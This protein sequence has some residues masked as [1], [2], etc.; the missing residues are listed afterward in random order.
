[1]VKIVVEQQTGYDTPT[2]AQK[3]KD[4]V[5]V[6][7]K[8]LND[9]QYRAAMMAYPDHH[10]LTKFTQA[11]MYDGG[12]VAS[13]ASPM[14][15]LLKGNGPDG[16][17]HVWLAV[18]HTLKNEVG[19]TVQN[20]EHNGVTLTKAGALDRLT[21]AQLADHIVHEHMHRIGYQHAGHETVERCDSIPYAYGRTVCAFATN[22]YASP[23]TC[24]KPADWPADQLAPRD[25]AHGPR[26]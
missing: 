11:T 8:V 12:N 17:I 24:D 15:A 1:M 14:D 13:N 6:A 3:L 19:H 26:C 22:K 7:E 20:A 2:R 21:V 16:Q 23:G 10:G 25:A 9:S 4:A 5:K 18:E